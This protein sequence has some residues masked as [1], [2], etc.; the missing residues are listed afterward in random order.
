MS[1]GVGRMFCLPKT[2]WPPTLLMYVV[3]KDGYAPRQFTVRGKR[4]SFSVGIIALSVVASLLV[5]MFEADTHLLIPLYSVGVFMSFT[6]A[7]SGMVIYWNKSKEPGW[8]RRAFING[9]GA[10]VTLVTT[11]IITYE[12]FTKGAWIVILIIPIIVYGMIRIKKHYDNVACRLRLNM[13][14]LKK[15]DLRVKYDHIIIVPIAS[16]NRAAVGALQYAQS[17]SS[18]VIALNIS[19]D[20]E[21]LEKLKKRWIALN[22]DIIL[23]AKYSPYRAV[24]TPLLGYINQIAGAAG[25]NEIV[26]VIL[27]EFE[28]HDKWGGFLHNHTSFFLRET[29]LRKNNIIV[30]TYPYH[31]TENDVCEMENDQ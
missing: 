8:Q 18:N 27:P 20:K 24:V 30:S 25:D 23:V 3:G 11:G 26:T 28:T 22:T 21:A 12:K 6:L 15:I 1:Q 2:A 7:Q 19:T 16:L 17:M 14:T 13:D 9:F 31:L 4:L 10:F 29:L 5:I